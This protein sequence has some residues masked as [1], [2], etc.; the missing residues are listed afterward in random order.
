[1]A[2]KSKKVEQKTFISKTGIEITGTV[3]CR[4]CMKDLHHRHFYQAVDQILDR[5][6]LMSVCKDCCQKLYDDAYQSERTTG[7]AFL[8][9][10]RI[11]N[12]V[13]DQRVVESVLAQI[14]KAQEE[15]RTPKHPFAI[16]RIRVSAILARGDETESE[17][18]YDLTFH[19]AI[20]EDSDEDEEMRD[21]DAL[22]GG[23]Y[24]Q[25][26]I[27]FLED[28]F[29]EFKRTYSVED[30]KATVTLLVLACKLLLEMKDK[31]SGALEKR[32]TNLYKEL[33]I[34]PQHQKAAAGGKLADALGVW[35]KEIEKY[36][37]AEWL[38]SLGDKEDLHHDVDNV[39]LY[40]Q[41]FVARP[42]KNFMQG[43]PDYNILDED[44]NV[45]SWEI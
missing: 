37:P 2:K 44:G 35:I 8:K 19:E 27:D 33:A 11:L 30:D 14:T 40:Y 4:M 21:H 43:S 39:D 9:V 25:E 34:S 36:Y 12:I 41:N 20:V 38:E 22:W 28:Q 42:I 45:E 29:R 15:E 23:D 26:E 13:F 31:P 5:N 18:N 6:G 17:E 10:C 7:R 32:L 1:M 24:S 16:Y 3:Y